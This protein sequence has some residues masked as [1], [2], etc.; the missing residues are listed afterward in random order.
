MA[1]SAPRVYLVDASAYVFRAWQ[2][3]PTSIRDSDGRAVNAV[4]GFG[5]FLLRL[6]EHECAE[7]IAVAFEGHNSN[8]TR[9]AIYPPYKRDRRD[10]PPELVHQ[11]KLC[12]TLAQAAGLAT[13]ERARREA[14]DVLA[15]LA[16]DVRA[17]GVRHTVLSGDKDLAQIV[18]T[19]DTW[20]DERRGLELDPSGIRRY[21]G[22]LPHQIPDWL[23]LAGDSSDGIPGVPGIGAATAARLLARERDLGALLAEPGAVRRMRFRGAPRAAKLLARH[24]ESVR[25]ARRLTGLFADDALVDHPATLQRR[26]PD[27]DAWARLRP[28]RGITAAQRRAWR[29]DLQAIAAR[30]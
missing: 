22:V 21:F 6:L 17:H 12:R 11:F 1:V 26:A 28:R 5:A 20:R 8:A 14:D 10:K 19:G 2:R 23:A 9:R 27:V 7:R 4:Y 16:A 29:D 18:R 24:A 3:W 15:T 25:L 30:D 13:F